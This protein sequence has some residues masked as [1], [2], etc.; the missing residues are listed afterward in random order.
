MQITNELK[1]RKIEFARIESDKH[2]PSH[3][4]RIGIKTENIEADFNND[5]WLIEGDIEKFIVD[6]ET[7]DQKRTGQAILE[8]MSPG[9]L[10]LAFRAIDNRG[11]L[12]VTCYFKREDRISNDYSFEMK[13]EF[14]I[15]PTSLPNV[16]N[17]MLA[18]IKNS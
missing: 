4:I 16:R 6:L 11:H 1:T 13:V 14:Q 17:E 3:H 9:E 10:E 5:V 2:Y 8:S 12:S 7:L 15:D 18:L